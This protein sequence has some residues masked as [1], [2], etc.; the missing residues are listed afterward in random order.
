[1]PL[2]SFLFSHFRTPIDKKLSIFSLYFVLTLGNLLNFI[3]NFHLCLLFFLGD[4]LNFIYNF[5]IDFFFKYC[6]DLF[7]MSKS[8]FWFLY[9]LIASA[10][11]IYLRKS[12]IVFCFT[13]YIVFISFKFPFSLLL[14]FDPFL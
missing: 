4:C 11:F 13:P 1:M 5:S 2:P 6:A 10:S 8:S 3:Y 12:F 9:F 7:S 14:C